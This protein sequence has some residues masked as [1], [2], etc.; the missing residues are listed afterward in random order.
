MRCGALRA[1]LATAIMLALSVPLSSRASL[2]N[3]RI[4][5][6]VPIGAQTFSAEQAIK[7]SETTAD[8][9]ATV[10]DGYWVESDGIKECIRVYKAGVQNDAEPTPDEAV[11]YFHGDVIRGGKWQGLRAELIAPDIYTTESPESLASAATTFSS[12]YKMPFFW[13]PRLG[14]YGST[15]EYFETNRK[16]AL[17][18]YS[19]LLDQIKARFRLKKLHLVGQSAGGSLVAGLI[20][21]RDDVGCAVMSSPNADMRRHAGFAS[22][23]GWQDYFN[24][25]NI[26]DG[27]S[28]TNAPRILVLSDPDDRQVTFSTQQSYVD[29]LR[30]AGQVPVHI[31][32]KASD[33]QSHSL[34][35]WGAATMVLCLRGV[36]NDLIKIGIER[37]SGRP[38][39]PSEEPTKDKGMP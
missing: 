4:A 18:L 14:V 23:G 11:F 34:A 5:M 36:T 32:A 20:T 13:V 29:A 38:D 26:S 2:F 17:P 9:C 10:P 28:K 25:A 30:R 22:Y 1:L 27:V 3:G 24:P 37:A 39:V 12:L 16:K 35:Q 15:G 21:L 8:Q 7:G 6:A 33:P 19:K 31:I